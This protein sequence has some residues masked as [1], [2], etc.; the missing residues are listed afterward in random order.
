[1]YMYIYTH[2]V[3]KYVYTY[4]HVSCGVRLPGT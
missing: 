3:H 2:I 4:I 1:M